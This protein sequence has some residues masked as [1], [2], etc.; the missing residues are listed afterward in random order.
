MW[1]VMSPCLESACIPYLLMSSNSIDSCDCSG[2]GVPLHGN[3]LVSHICTYQI[4]EA[5]GEK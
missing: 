3:L 5:L 2:G 4:T 1:C